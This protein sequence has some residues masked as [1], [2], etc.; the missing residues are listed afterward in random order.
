MSA[1]IPNSSTPASST[2]TRGHGSAEESTLPPLTAGPY[3]RRLSVV[4]FIATIGGLLFGYDTGVI[5]GALRPMTIELGLTPLTEGVVT[6]SLLFGAAVGAMLGGRLADLWGRKRTIMLLAF[7]FL[8]GAAVCALSPSFG[9]M[10]VGRVILGIAVGA[11]STVVPVYLA[12]LAPHE[13]RG[14]LSGRNEVMIAVGA[15]A[16]FA[17]NAIIGNVWGHLDS[18]WRVMLAI[19]AIPAIAL[20]LGMIRMPESPRWLIAHGRRDEALEI[21]RT[22]RPEARAVAEIDEA[23]ALYAAS[24]N[25]RRTRLSAVLKNR[26]LL[27]ILLIGIGIA[28]FQQL[29]GINTIVYYGQTVLIEA[30]FEA[31]AALIANVVPGAIGVLGS[32]ASLFM[33]E[34]I[35]RRTMFM[36]GYGLVTLCHVL[37]GLSSIMFPVGAPARPY[38]IL[39]LVVLFVGSMQTFLNV[40]TWVILSEIFPLH[41]R[42]LGIGIAVFCMWI[43]N[44]TL[45]LFFPSVVDGVGITGS[46]FMLGVFNLIAFVFVLKFLPETRGRTLESIEED[47]STGAIYLN[48]K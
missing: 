3:R 25:A 37:I 27:R 23:E 26:W 5:N 14:S 6:S 45:G 39:V 1:S 28:V 22:I 20:F 48:K 24:K 29:T 35:N 30:G 47:V 8:L 43:A 38:V 15:F 7:A 17:V 19:C 21:M 9:V 18:I 46:F 4:A 10:V 41:M 32:I 11:A 2:S 16:A 36:C 12:E 44:A 33:M 42:G 34:R 13:I 40:A 31:D